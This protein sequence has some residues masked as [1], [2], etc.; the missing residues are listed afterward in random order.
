[1]DVLFANVLKGIVIKEDLG[2]PRL[3]DW[4]LYGYLISGHFFADLPISPDRKGS[5]ICSKYHMH[6]AEPRRYIPLKE[7]QDESL[8]F[9]LQKPPHL[10]HLSYQELSTDKHK[11]STT[12]LS[13]F[14]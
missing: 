3:W 2:L 10:G 1:M 8:S 11:K 6:P 9:A 5:L 12:D 13:T 14:F 7:M 4:W